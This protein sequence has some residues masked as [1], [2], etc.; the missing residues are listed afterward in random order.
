MIHYNRKRYSL[1][2]CSYHAILSAI[3]VNRDNPFPLHRAS[4]LGRH[5]MRRMAMWFYCTRSS[6]RA[7]DDRLDVVA[8]GLPRA[9]GGGE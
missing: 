5:K 6:L 2:D 4:S 9:K 3:H 7:V 1:G 8:S